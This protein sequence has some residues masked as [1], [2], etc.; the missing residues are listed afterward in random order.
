[1]KKGSIID[2]VMQPLFVTMVALGIVLVILLRSVYSIGSSTG[3]E[4]QFYAVDAALLI[5]SIQAVRSDANLEVKYGVPMGARVTSSKVE[6]AS[7]SFPFSSSNYQLTGGTIGPNS[8]IVRSGSTIS[9]STA[10]LALPLPICV[11]NLDVRGVHSDN[12][13]Y[14]RG[15][16]VSP[17]DVVTGNIRVRASLNPSQVRALKVYVKDSEL[18][19]QLGCKI[20]S[21]LVPKI[22][23]LESVSIVPIYRALL[24]SSDPKSFDGEGIFI[25]VSAPSDLSIK[26]AIVQSINAEVN[27]E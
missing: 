8:R 2:I 20:A 15:M 13:E 21:R 3:F 6:V 24:S 18:S 23:G 7:K 17:V 10:P 27:N 12:L 1:M 5:D 14:L 22:A 9:V 16:D 11:D 25:E 26:G 19:K 4:E